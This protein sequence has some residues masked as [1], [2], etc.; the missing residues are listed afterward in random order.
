MLNPFFELIEAIFDA[1]Q[2]LASWC[3]TGEWRWVMVGNDIAGN[4]N[5]TIAFENQLKNIEIWGS[6]TKEDIENWPTDLTTTDTTDI[7]NRSGELIRTEEAQAADED[8][9]INENEYYI[10][11]TGYIDNYEYPQIVYSPEEIFTGKIEILN[12]NFISSEVANSS[13]RDILNVISYWF[14]ALRY[15]GIAALLS[16]L[17]YIG[18]KTI[19]S[20]TGQERSKYK[21]SIFSWIIA[22]I[23]LVVLQYIISF[24]FYISENIISNLETNFEN[25]IT[26][27]VYDAYAGNDSIHQNKTTYTKFTTNILGLVR[28]QIQNRDVIKKIAYTL[29]Y[30]FLVFY[31]V[32]FTYI[33]L[34][35]LIYIAILIIISPI[36]AIMYPIDKLREKPNRSLA[37]WIR[38][39]LFN[40]LIQP[41]HTIL[42][43]ILI[44]SAKS[45]TMEN[46]IYLI[47][48]YEFISRSEKI[49]RNIFEDSNHEIGTV[50]VIQRN[51]KKLLSNIKNNEEKQN[52]NEEIFKIDKNINQKEVDKKLYFIKRDENKKS[53]EETD[54]LNE[55]QRNTP[56]N[57]IEE[58][59]PNNKIYIKGVY[60]QRDDKLREFKIKDEKNMPKDKNSKNEE[61][62]DYI[63]IAHKIFEENK[64]QNE[65]KLTEKGNK[66]KE[67]YKDKEEGKINLEIKRSKQL[68]KYGIED[69]N[70]QI[71]ISKF[72]NKL[73]DERFDSEYSKDKFK[74]KEERNNF[75]KNKANEIRK[76]GNNNMKQ[77]RDEDV[78]KE[79][80]I[81]KENYLDLAIKTLKLKE[82][83]P[84]EVINGN[85]EEKDKWINSQIEENGNKR[86][87][88]EFAIKMVNKMDNTKY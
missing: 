23:L 25:E 77:M 69:N 7:Y 8:K 87:D 13:W 40:I 79:D 11:A 22:L 1:I 3:I 38:E 45:F 19:I 62:I 34:K 49:L 59:R 88:L 37:I 75:I 73:A 74:T 68:S 17:I 85:S 31:T 60:L 67:I 46:I 2:S 18:I 5:G 61:K 83:I 36:V 63:S 86:E 41:V 30:I 48:V 76:K 71:Q 27:Y 9:A 35:R 64:E 57:K 50:T 14:R 72:I 43:S 12:A 70:E 39:L 56:S 42:Y 58:R 4:L 55:L 51:E 84:K 33:Y 21:D 44:L 32:K 15:I 66:Y 6:N 80:I 16:I 26:V 65:K 81:E 47:G 54:S 24:V 78:I 52:I 53:L 10:N 82:Q 29:F 20:S 28:F